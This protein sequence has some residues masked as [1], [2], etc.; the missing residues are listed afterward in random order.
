MWTENRLGSRFFSPADSSKQTGH[1]HLS[2]HFSS[3][4]L[5][6]LRSRHCQSSTASFQYL[7]PSLSTS[8]YSSSGLLINFV[9]AH[10]FGVK[11]EYVLPTATKVAFSVF[12]RVFV[13]PAEL[14]YASDTPA[15]WSNRLTAGEATRPV[16]RGAGIRRTLTEPQRPDCFVGRECGS[17]RLVPQ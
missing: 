10:R 1:A 8:P 5:A 4:T 16:P 17:P 2:S 12:S 15:N 3:A 11:K 14:V 6:S 7:F 13:L 9:S